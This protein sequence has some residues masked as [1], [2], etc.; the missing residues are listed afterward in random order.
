MRI[1]NASHSVLQSPRLL[2]SLRVSISTYRER[3]LTDLVWNIWLVASKYPFLMY[4]YLAHTSTHPLSKLRVPVLQALTFSAPF[5]HLFL[6]P[7]AITS[8]CSRQNKFLIYATL[9]IKE[10]WG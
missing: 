10:S 4:F 6:M 9:P 2:A 3:L 7:D 1:R 5:H 8:C